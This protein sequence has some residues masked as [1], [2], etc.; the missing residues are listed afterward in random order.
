MGVSISARHFEVWFPGFGLLECSVL[1]KMFCCAGGSGCWLFCL[2][3]LVGCVQ[4]CVQVIWGF[5]FSVR[6]IKGLGAAHVYKSSF[7]H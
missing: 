3:S 4:G 7:R 6:D 2:S 5:C 1:L